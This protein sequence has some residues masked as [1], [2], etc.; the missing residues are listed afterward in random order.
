[1]ESGFFMLY[2]FLPMAYLLFAGIVM[3]FVAKANKMIDKSNQGATLKVMAGTFLLFAVIIFVSYY[4][5]GA[6]L[7]VI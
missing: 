4:I 7:V 2:S 3:Y 5:T 1:M 6:F